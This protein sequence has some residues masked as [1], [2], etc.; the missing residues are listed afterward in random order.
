LEAA[1]IDT[2]TIVPTYSDQQPD[3]AA[4]QI[5]RWTLARHYKP[6]VENK[7]VC[8]THSY[9]ETKAAVIEALTNPKQYAAGRTSIVERYVCFSDHESSRRVAE[10]IAGVANAV[11]PGKPRGL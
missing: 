1:I 6:L 3:H 4:A 2:P 11:R 7:W 8:V 5:G 9:Q 10:W